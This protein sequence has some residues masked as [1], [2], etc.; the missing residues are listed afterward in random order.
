MAH[1]KQT[2]WGRSVTR[3]THLTQAMIT[4]KQ[5]IDT[6]IVEKSPVTSTTAEEMAN[7]TKRA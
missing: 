3:P 5:P 4:R 7:P 2:A 1:T 6:K